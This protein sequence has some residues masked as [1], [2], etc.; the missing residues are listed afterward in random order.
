MINSLA[1]RNILSSAPLRLCVILMALLIALSSCKNKKEDIDA[2]VNKT[3][4]QE[5][6]ATDVTIIMSKNGRV[7]G[8]LFAKDFI[9]NDVA[10]PPFTDIKNGLKLEI[11]GDSMNVESTLTARYARYYEAAGN[12]IV[13]DSIV[14]INKKG[15]KLSTEELVWNQK[16]EKFYTEKFVRITTA[17]QVI[18]GDGMEA[19][20]DFTWYRI[21]NIKG[22]LQVNKSDVPL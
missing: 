12:I 14:I 6:K 19:N 2:L 3:I 8:R 15:E 22:I 1:S 18:Y 5:D 16:L 17:T 21:H 9:R 11:Y 10:K 20:Q 4:L 7:E 13:R